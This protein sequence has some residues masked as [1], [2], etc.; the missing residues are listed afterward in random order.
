M[1]KFRE[2][3]VMLYLSPELYVGFVKLQADKGLGR[4]YAALLCFIEGLH[5]FGYV[6]KE[7]HERHKE[8]YSLPLVQQKSKPL[9]KEEFEKQQ[10]LEEWEKRFSRAIQQWNTMNK[11]AREYYI[12]K[13]KKLCTNISN[14]ELILALANDNKKTI[15]TEVKA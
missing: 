5:K 13:A 12:E 9:T 15:E 8:K 10:K 4:S 2:H 3:G 1:G 7:V 6:T 14:A 11:K